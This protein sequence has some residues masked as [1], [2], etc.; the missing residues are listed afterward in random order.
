MQFN[1]FLSIRHLYKTTFIPHCHPWLHCC[2]QFGYSHKGQ[3]N[4]HNSQTG[5]N[6]MA[7]MGTS[8]LPGIFIIRIVDT[9]YTIVM[10]F[11]IPS[12][13]LCSQHLHIDGLVQVRCNS[14]VLA[15]ELCLS[16]IVREC[17]ERPQARKTMWQINPG[18]VI[19]HN[20]RH[21]HLICNRWNTFATWQQ[22][23]QPRYCH[24]QR[25]VCKQWIR[26]DMKETHIRRIFD[27]LI[28]I[29][30]HIKDTYS[31]WMDCETAG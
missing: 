9:S 3:E 18:R 25:R 21:Y 1:T 23:W 13:A 28:Y 11:I 22:K 15:M 20:I 10:Q 30:Q 26:I 29:W 17:E 7:Q 19:C 12:N 14:S 2:R 24:E 16:Y 4:T 5:S 6:L 8:I 27:T 31:W